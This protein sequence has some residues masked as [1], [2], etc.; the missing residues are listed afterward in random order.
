MTM[1]GLYQM[2]DEPMWRGINAEAIYEAVRNF[3]QGLAAE[4]FPYPTSHIPD[5]VVRDGKGNVIHRLKPDP[6]AR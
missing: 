1:N 4:I 6:Y 2:S 5:P 3:D